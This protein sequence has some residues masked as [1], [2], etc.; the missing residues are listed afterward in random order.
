MTAAGGDVVK[1]VNEESFQ[2]EVVEASGRVPILVDFWASWCGPCRT[3]SPILEK[4]AVEYQGSFVLAKVNTEE[5]PRLAM[6]FGI[7]GIPHCILFRD[8]RPIDQFVGAYPESVVR[9]FLA[10]YCLSEADKLFAVAER[11]LQA[12]KPVE[13]EN[14]FLEI[15]RLDPRHAPTHLSLAKLLIAAKRSEEAKTHLD[16]IPAMADEYGTASRLREVLAFHEDCEQAGGE[17]NCRKKVEG[18]PKDLE[19][20]FGLASCLAWEGKYQEAL[21]EFLAIIVKDK[22]FRDEAPRRA[23]L[24]IFSLVGERSDLAEEYRT[25]LARTLY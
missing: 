2:K 17:I 18:N 24:A 10:P 1:V 21:D 7:Q 19:A 8:G 11:S 14:L 16:A 13:A 23:M 3:L 4:L 20:R 22:H 5:S 25:R 9:K 15:L 6:E 12:G